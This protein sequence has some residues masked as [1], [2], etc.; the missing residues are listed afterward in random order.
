MVLVA[1][2]KKILYYTVADPARGLRN[3]KNITKE[4]IWQRRPPTHADRSEKMKY[5]SRDASTCLGATQIS[6][7]SDHCLQLLET[8]GNVPR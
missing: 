8:G 6:V 7:K 1:N 4:E 3:R 2:Q 5:K